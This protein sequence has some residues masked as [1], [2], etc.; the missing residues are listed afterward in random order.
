MS[1]QLNYHDYLENRSSTTAV[2]KC[3]VVESGYFQN[4]TQKNLEYKF[5]TKKTKIKHDTKNY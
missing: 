5:I 4:K 2:N 3:N 1:F